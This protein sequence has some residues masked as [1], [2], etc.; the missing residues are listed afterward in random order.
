MSVIAS[1]GQEAVGEHYRCLNTGSL[2]GR[3]ELGQFLEEVE[4][5]II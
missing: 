4:L 2:S 5:G 1:W 3:E